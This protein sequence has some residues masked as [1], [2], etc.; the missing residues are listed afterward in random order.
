MAAVREGMAE[1][2]LLVQSA[3]KSFAMGAWR[4]GWIV[5]SPVFTTVFARMIECM[6]LAV[7][8]VA[9]AAVAA[10]IRGP[11][12]WLQDLAAEFQGN[13]DLAVRLLGEVDGVSFV[14]P[15]GGPFLLPDVSG[16]GV[17]GDAF[18]ERLIIEHGLRVNGGSYYNS[19]ECI[20]IPFG[21][22]HAA[23]EES[24]RRIQTAV[25]KLKLGGEP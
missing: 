1:R 12:D 13:R 3:T 25:E 20:R 5:A 23:I 19:P 8:H 18:C 24:F 17:A 15:Q 7:N 21:G 6:M 22:T 9:Q 11:Q 10:A 2:T 4:V 14:V 16:L